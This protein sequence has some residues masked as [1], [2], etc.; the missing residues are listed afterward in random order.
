MKECFF[1]L[2]SD[3]SFEKNRQLNKKRRSFPDKN[4]IPFSNPLIKNTQVVA[5]RGAVA[6]LGGLSSQTSA[7][8]TTLFNAES[9]AAATKDALDCLLAAA[10]SGPKGR[11]AAAAAGG[12]AAA[13]RALAGVDSSPHS[14]LSLRVPPPQWMGRAARLIA[15]LLPVAVL[16][17][18][19][20]GGTANASAAAGDLAAAAPALA[21]LLSPPPEAL[22][23]AAAAAAA[24]ARASGRA[25]AESDAASDQ[26]D[27][28]A[29]LDALASRLDGGGGGGEGGRGG[30]GAAAAA[31]LG[32]A[33]AAL[34]LSA[35]PPSAW[36][37]AARRGLAGLLRA[38]AGPSVRHAAL[39][40]AA[41]VASLVSEGSCGRASW[42]LL[43]PPPA[44]GPPTKTRGKNGSDDASAPEFLRVLS[45]VSRVEAALLFRDAEDGDTLVAAPEAAAAAGLGG[46]SGGAAAVAATSAVSPAG[47]DENDED[48][49]DA[50]LKP[51]P[52]LNVTAG[53]LVAAAGRWH[54]KKKTGSGGRGAGPGSSG[55]ARPQAASDE[56][57][58][59]RN[60]EP[61]ASRAERTL[62]SVLALVEAALDALA[63]DAEAG[64]QRALERK[65]GGGGGGVG[66]GRDAEL[67]EILGSGG[68]DDD[69]DL[70]GE[71]F[72]DEVAV[73]AFS[74]LKDAV[75]QGLDYLEGR[76]PG[77]SALRGSRVRDPSSSAAAAAAPLSPSERAAR[78]LAP[79]AARCLGRLL[80]DA[81]AAFGARP[82]ALLPFLL[83][84]PCGVGEGGGGG[85]GTCGRFFL[86]VLSG[87]LAAEQ[88]DGDGEEAE[89]THEERMA[90]LSLDDGDAGAWLSAARRPE[91]LAGLAATLAAACSDAAAA[92]AADRGGAEINDGDG[93]V[94]AAAAVLTGLL[95]RPSPS[96]YAPLRPLLVPSL[97]SWAASRLGSRKS[98]S[99]SKGGRGQKKRQKR[100]AAGGDG[101]AASLLS[102]ANEVARALALLLACPPSSSQDFPASAAAA[103]SAA[104]VACLRP[105]WA[106]WTLR[107]QKNKNKDEKKD[108]GGC[109]GGGGA[110]SMPLLEGR[111]EGEGLEQQHERNEFGL[112]TTPME[113][114]SHLDDSSTAVLMEEELE[115]EAEEEGGGGDDQYDELG[116]LLRFDAGGQDERGWSRAL[117]AAALVAEGDSSSSGAFVAAASSAPWLRELLE[118]ETDVAPPESKAAA[119]LA[120]RAFVG[121]LRRRLSQ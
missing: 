47:G 7:T 38:R 57:G 95:P 59:A 35:A 22:L 71:L 99:E 87:A 73:R 113:D 81:P 51:P 65:S 56:D 18:R 104:L 64:E 67:D 23:A 98:E 117:R 55:G 11:G 105:G 27:A 31:A 89:G 17:G 30:G 101:A 84:L 100:G 106:A 49:G 43:P 79:A 86:P 83:Q 115:Q 112:S 29:A 4:I 61:A 103:S 45:E 92:A 66:G 119:A 70:S 25:C 78:S 97:A 21:A 85:G 58:R 26:L 20:V 15:L 52:R 48:D 46:G 110:R 1:F 33:R 24:A 10:L 41:F 121:A 118:Q 60:L 111:E 77:L 80:A 34:A 16:G 42:L 114:A 54:E 120:L 39:R 62:P 107:S 102:T 6:A 2:F 116:L 9:E 93:E 90:S 63:N 40:V 72:N 75:E 3:I 91:A 94:A 82:R 36:P 12:A 28:L 50:G 37:A 108:N 76:A 19:G 32:A 68:S 96:H 53:D 13:A 109:G 5:A 44:A 8:T 74:S 14:P 69:G 88:Q